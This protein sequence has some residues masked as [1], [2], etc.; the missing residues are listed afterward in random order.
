MLFVCEDNGYAATTR[1]ASMT[2]GSGTSARA[3]A[4]GLLA[5]EVDGN[6]VLAVDEAATRL[7]AEIREGGGPRFLHAR[8]YRITGHTGADPAGYRPASEVEEARRTDPIARA[9]ETLAAAGVSA[10]ELAADRA[11]AER[12]M[13]EAYGAALAAP[14]PDPAEALRDVQDVGSPEQDAY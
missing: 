4:L 14:F 11:A 6:D 3:R 7:V 13:A 5:T 10:G 9:A 12:E 2:A 8:T 1:T